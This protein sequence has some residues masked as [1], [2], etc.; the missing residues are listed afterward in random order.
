[1]YCD[2]IV[3]RR[4]VSASWA[5]PRGARRPESPEPRREVRRRSRFTAPRKHAAATS[6]IGE[7]LAGIAEIPGEACERVGL[8]PAAPRRP[9]ARAGAHAAAA[10]RIGESLAETARTGGNPCKKFAVLRVAPNDPV[11]RILPFFPSSRAKPP[12]GRRSRGTSSCCPGI[13]T[14]PSAPRFALRSG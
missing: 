12:D 9:A 3:R 5:S 4:A 7:S 8:A 1:M 10:A 2:P 13:R 11:Y 6:L 14:G